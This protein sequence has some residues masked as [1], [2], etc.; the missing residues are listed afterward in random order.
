MSCYSLSFAIKLVTQNVRY[1]VLISKTI[2]KKTILLI[3]NLKNS[4]TALCVR[5]V[6]N[7]ISM[8]LTLLENISNSETKISTDFTI[9]IV[10]PI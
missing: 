2:Q 5:Q 6:F 9:K 8:H 10:K 4:S 3:Y 7:L 1:K